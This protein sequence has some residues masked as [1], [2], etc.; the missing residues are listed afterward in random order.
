MIVEKQLPDK[1]CIAKK[2]VQT[3][4]IM[5]AYT[6]EEKA[7][8]HLMYGAAN[9]DATA[10]RRLYANRFPTRATPDRSMFERIHRQL[11]ETGSF[12]AHRADTGPQRAMDH[13]EPILQH[14]ANNPSTSVRA[15]AA[16][17]GVSRSTVQRVLSDDEQHPYHFQRV[18]SLKPADYLPRV[19]FCKWFLQKMETQPDF[20]NLVLFSDEATFT[21]EGVFNSHNSHCWAHTNPHMIRQHA[22]QTQFSVNVWAGIIGNHLIGP[23]LFPNRLDG[24]SYFNFVQEILPER[25]QNVPAH[26]RRIM[27]FQQDGAPAHFRREVRELLNSTYGDQWIGRE[28]P[29][30]WPPRSPDLTS[31]DFFLWGHLKNLVYETPV[32]SQEEL[33]ARIVAAAGKIQDDTDMLNRVTQSLARRYMACIAVGGRSFEQLLK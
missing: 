12:H 14:V 15:V 16:R 23:C 5:A 27:W 4:F 31:L 7:D 33:V 30:R 24:R 13:E 11:R 17:C 32:T 1:R 8:M 6:N 20:P 29:I 25:L 19:E 18:H 26:I 9:C 28:G 22:H 2:V 3:L 10:A 21:R